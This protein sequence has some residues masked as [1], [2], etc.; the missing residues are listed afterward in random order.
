MT[1]LN[2]SVVESKKKRIIVRDMRPNSKDDD[3]AVFEL[4]DDETM[5]GMYKRIKKHFKNNMDQDKFILATTDRQ[6]IRPTQDFTKLKHNETLIIL[7]HANQELPRSLEESIRFEPHYHTLT[8][9]GAYEYYSSENRKGLT[10]AFAELVDNSL[11]ATMYN[12]DRKQKR[13]IEIR[14]YLDAYNKT[15]KDSMIVVADNGTGM[16]T[17]E[18]N[19]WAIFK[20]SKFLRTER[21]LAR[22]PKEDA[23]FSNDDFSDTT[24]YP[25]FLN[26]QIS[27]FGA[28][29]KQ[30]VF[31]IGKSVHII[32]KSI[33]LVDV[34]EMIISESE[35]QQKEKD[36]KDTYEGQITSRP[37]G[38][39]AKQPNET[40]KDQIVRSLVEEEKTKG[41]CFTYFCISDIVGDHHQDLSDPEECMAQLANIYHYYIHGPKGNYTD[42]ME[43]KQSATPEIC[44]DINIE[45]VTYK[46]TKD[47]GQSSVKINRIARK[48]LT[49]VQD[50]ETNLIRSAKDTFEFSGYVS[51]TLQSEAV[52]APTSKVQKMFQGVLR[53]YPFQYDKE[54]L[55][56]FKYTEKDSKDKENDKE[57]DSDDVAVSKVRRPLF[58]CYW[59]GRLIPYTHINHNVLSWTNSKIRGDAPE[60]CYYRTAGSFFFNDGFKVTQNK[61]TFQENITEILNGAQTGKWY[62]PEVAYMCD[63]SRYVAQ[64][65]NIEKALKEWLKD[66]HAKHD[67]QIRFYGHSAEL[68]HRTDLR[69][70]AYEYPWTKFNRIVWDKK[71]MKV[72]D[73]VKTCKTSPIVVGKIEGFYLHRDLRKEAADKEKSAAK[74]KGIYGNIGWVKLKV[75]PVELGEE[76]FYKL[77]NIDREA[78]VTEVAK[79]A[80]KWANN[81]P[82]EI[83]VEFLEF[84][85][86]IIDSN[87]E[88]VLIAKGQPKMKK[89]DPS[90]INDGDM[91]AAGSHVG[92]FKVDI[93]DRTGTSLKGIMPTSGKNKGK[94]S[95]T[96]RLS[97]F[98]ENAEEQRKQVAKFEILNYTEENGFWFGA[99]SE[100]WEKIGCYEIL[101][102]A[103]VRKGKKLVNELDDGFMLPSKSIKFTVHSEVPSYIISPAMAGNFQRIGEPVDIPMTFEDF[104]KNPA[105]PVEPYPVSFRVLTPG[106]EIKHRETQVKGME[107]VIKDVTFFGKLKNA[108]NAEKV[109]YKILADEKAAEPFGECPM[110]M[111]LKSGKPHVLRIF[112]LEAIVIENGTLPRVGAI[113]DDISGNAVTFATEDRLAIHCKFYEKKGNVKKDMPGAYMLDYD[114]NRN[115]PDG[116]LVNVKGDGPIKLQMKKGE[117]R[118]IV[119]RFFLKHPFGNVLAVEKEIIVK[120]SCVPKSVKF[121]CSAEEDSTQIIEIPDDLSWTAG[122]TIQNISFRFYDEVGD[123]VKKLNLSSSNVEIS[124]LQDPYVKGYTDDDLNK[125]KLPILKAPNSAGSGN[126]LHCNVS[127]HSDLIDGR[128]LTVKRGFNVISRPGPARMIV[129]HVP[130]EADVIR[131]GEHQ[132]K[133][134]RVK[135]VDKYNNAI[136]G[137]T[138]TSIQKLLFSCRTNPIEEIDL[139][140][141]LKVLASGETVIEVTGIK[142]R[143]PTLGDFIVTLMYGPLT[144]D[145]K[146]TL[147]PGLPKFMKWVFRKTDFDSTGYV[148]VTKDSKIGVALQ[149]YDAFQNI[150]PKKDILVQL[151]VASR[152][153]VK[154][155][156][157]YEE[158][159]KT[160]MTDANGLADFGD[161]FVSVNENCPLVPCPIG[162]CPA[163]CFAAHQIKA[164]ATIESEIISSQPIM[165][166]HVRCDQTKPKKFLVAT[167]G[168]V[169]DGKLLTSIQA[170]HQMPKFQV[171]LQA[172]DDT[173]IETRDHNDVVAEICKLPSREPLPLV[174]ALK[175]E[176]SK[177]NFEIVAPITAG[178]YQIQFCFMQMDVTSIK[179]LEF[180]FDVKPDVPVRFE[181]I[182]HTPQD[183]CVANTKQKQSRTVTGKLDFQLYDKYNNMVGCDDENDEY[184]GKLFITIISPDDNIVPSLASTVDPIPIAK[185]KSSVPSIVLEENSPGVDGASYILRFTSEFL[186][187]NKVILPMYDIVFTFSNDAEKQQRLNEIATAKNK[188]SEEKNVLL[189]RQKNL[190]QEFE[191]RTL[192]RNNAQRERQNFLQNWRRS[193]RSV[194]G[195]ADNLSGAQLERTINEKEAKVSRLEEADRK[196]LQSGR[197]MEEAPNEPGILGKF[198]H[199]A[200]LDDPIAA[201]VLSWHMQGDMDTIVTYNT[202]KAEELNRR[203]QERQQLMPL[204]Q[205]YRGAPVRDWFGMLP[206]ERAR[207]AN[208]SVTGNPVFARTLLDFP[209][210]EPNCKIVFASLLGDTILMDSLEDALRYRRQIVKLPNMQCPTIVTR[211]GRRLRNNGKFGGL[212]NKM[213]SDVAALRQGVFGLAPNRNIA[214]ERAVIE[215]LRKLQSFSRKVEEADVELGQFKADNRKEE[216][217]LTAKIS[218]VMKEIADYD[219]K[220]YEET[221]KSH[222]HHVPP[223]LSASTARGA[224]DGPSTPLKRAASSNSPDDNIKRRR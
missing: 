192:V 19:N 123:E 128:R 124:W 38:D 197:R 141:T 191:K 149:L 87:G 174:K 203:Y 117:E 41:D 114:N 112:P 212:G 189:I 57:D 73:T 17:E 154:P 184:S 186:E 84:E 221:N 164:K 131:L 18:M 202:E 80:T 120:P 91:I 146:M 158:G 198:C 27:Y 43:K 133:P 214:I 134:I 10:M 99:M 30:A 62:S 182:T 139:V 88:P 176:E 177:W 101:I 24:K 37:V 213:P 104:Y 83:T 9:S 196:R 152:L 171:T 194:D 129:L 13:N 55:P 175:Y 5:M 71:P 85:T 155:D 122:D 188:L 108:V 11:G 207:H 6:V 97:V 143:N 130:D 205:I 215:N 52:E 179:S 90:P 14:F 183:L 77:S 185:G 40:V 199:L 72:G 150:S 39:I 100:H 7:T 193:E 163:R 34:K 48:P 216:E 136:E 137:L 20:K 170:G 109:E 151:G 70:R 167:D 4:D 92:A 142:F 75:L 15:R 200:L 8:E 217:E 49:E 60:E 148:P 67:K 204:D 23:S 33:K 195:M 178:Q 168:E 79:L 54:T 103:L 21:N 111:T 59:N 1:S 76:K 3:S 121:F 209:K 159:V 102:E 144:K 35:F 26:S 211:D 219:R 46:M 172:D 29:G 106:F 107:L 2:D 89:H 145:M 210:D 16:T 206:H 110:T 180:I 61:L 166:F 115:N 125:G 28:G 153:V 95:F 12:R 86:G 132:T 165:K 81:V 78:P 22:T 64:R 56:D 31:F 68:F 222:G 93:L 127:F 36:Q 208:I 63:D 47:K 157:P 118:T 220:A 116:K 65:K 160:Q 190:N 94:S 96:V 66:C 135:I 32:S 113:I 42:D 218:Q 74:D 25:R 169:D 82:A 147:V 162:I 51:Q 45:F 98:A 201:Q 138:E 105:A 58:D 173:V 126:K 53:Y 156:F 161:C 69:N 187:R 50:E 224:G 44:K 119:G 140:K 223:P 181:P